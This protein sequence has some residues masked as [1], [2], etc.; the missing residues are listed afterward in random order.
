M[1]DL[2]SALS[3]TTVVAPP[4]MVR[5][6]QAHQAA[7]HVAANHAIAT[8]GTAVIGDDMG[9]GKTQLASGLVAE[10]IADGGY[11]VVIA[12]PVT[13]AGWS[14]DM[15]AAFP[16]LRFAQ[17]K[18]TKPDFANLPIADVYWLSDHSVTMQ[19]WLTTKTTEKDQYGKEHTVFVPNAFALGAKVLVRDEIHRDKGANGKA[20]TGRA[21]VMMAVGKALPGPGNADHRDDRHA[22]DEPG[23]RGLRAAAVPRW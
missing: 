10:R 21:K 18:G 6:Y 3:T 5:P 15:Q 7:G 23:G 14:N 13:W 1:F 17:V 9:L 20:T 11:A 16:H 22:A 12:P 19:N 2:S 8:F 4:G